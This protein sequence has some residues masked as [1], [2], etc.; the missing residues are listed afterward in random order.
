[1]SALTP[2]QIDALP[3]YTNAQMV[4]LIGNCIAQLNSDPD[5]L[6]RM[7]NGR[8]YRSKDMSH[9]LLMLT[10]YEELARIDVEIA[11]DAAGLNSCPVV[12]FQENPI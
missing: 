6:V 10:H 9:I 1:M 7:P 12:R 2:A 8:E 5:G 3:V 4:K 11:A